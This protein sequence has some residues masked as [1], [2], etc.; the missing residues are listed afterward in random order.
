MLVV[1]HEGPNAQAEAGFS[2]AAR[3][4]ESTYR[5]ILKSS[6]LVG[7]SQ[8]LNVAIGIVRTKAMAILLGPAG[9]GLFGLY[10][11]I[12]DLTQNVAGMGVNSSGVRQIAEA[13]A[14]GDWTRIAQTAGVL[15]KI[16]ICLGLLGAIFLALFSKQ[17]SVL[18]F[19]DARHAT[20]VSLVSIA[21]FLR[22]VSAG[23][24]ALIQGMRR[25]SDLARMNVLSAAFGTAVA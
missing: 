19:G 22:L 13:S 25:I 3:P 2:E 4:E 12:S 15:R 5:Q 9:F 8:L 11:S 24:V 14:S 6:A 16:S 18:S 1:A 10:G 23:Q 17:V 20:G 7:G 21:V